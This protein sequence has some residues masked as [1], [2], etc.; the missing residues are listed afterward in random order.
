MSLFSHILI[1][2]H[3]KKVIEFSVTAAVAIQVRVG[4]IYNTSCFED[5]DFSYSQPYYKDVW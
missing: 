5:V 4:P 1:G 3:P 2:F